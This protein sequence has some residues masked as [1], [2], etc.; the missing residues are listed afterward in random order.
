MVDISKVQ[1]PQ[2]GSVTAP[3]KS[4]KERVD[5]TPYFTPWKTYGGSDGFQGWYHWMLERGDMQTTMWNMKMSDAERLYSVMCE[6]MREAH[7]KHTV[8]GKVCDFSNHPKDC[9]CGGS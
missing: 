4:L 8:L 3:P 9:D 7:R 6:A 1:L 5:E 2:G